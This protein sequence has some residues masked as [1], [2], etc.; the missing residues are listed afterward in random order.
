MALDEDRDAAL[1]LV[2]VDEQVDRTSGLTI[3]VVFGLS[4]G[5]E[6]SV[7]RM[8]DLANRT[9]PVPV[10]ILVVEEAVTTKRPFLRNEIRGSSQTGVQVGS[11]AAG[12]EQ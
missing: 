4:E 2:G 8:Q 7:A 1:L 11:E 9:M 6:R 10:G 3:G 12:L 5:L